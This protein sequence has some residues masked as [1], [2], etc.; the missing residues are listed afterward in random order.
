MKSRRY[1]MSYRSGLRFAV[2]GD[3]YAGMQG[4]WVV[5]HTLASLAYNIDRLIFHKRRAATG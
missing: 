4:G 1:S 3:I 5:N 2:G